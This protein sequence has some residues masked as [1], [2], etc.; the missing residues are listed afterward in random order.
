MNLNL[1]PEHFAGFLIAVVIITPFFKG[2]RLIRMIGWLGLWQLLSP[3]RGIVEDGLML[4]VGF[5]IVEWCY[6]EC[7]EHI[8]GVFK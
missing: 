6:L 3:V 2:G 4:A 7:Q 1:T 8:R 5:W